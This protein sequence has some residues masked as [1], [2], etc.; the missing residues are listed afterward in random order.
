MSHAYIPTLPQIHR[1]KHRLDVLAEIN[2]GSLARCAATEGS[3]IDTV[4][5]CPRHDAAH[6]ALLSARHVAPARSI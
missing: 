6:Y 3:C 5:C 1:P 2:W 4:L